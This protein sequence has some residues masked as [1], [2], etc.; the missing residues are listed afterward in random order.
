M[1]FIIAMQ[2]LIADYKRGL[3][4]ISREKEIVTQKTIR[5]F[6]HD[7]DHPGT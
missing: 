7:P 2:Q 5:D 1:A 6:P 3:S 4:K